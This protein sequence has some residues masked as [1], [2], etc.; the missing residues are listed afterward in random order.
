[1][2]FGEWAKIRDEKIV[3]VGYGV[4]LPFNPSGGRYEPGY[5]YLLHVGSRKP[6][7]NLARL[8]KAFAISGVRKNVRLVL[9]GTR[10]R[11]IAAQIEDLGLN[12]DVKFVGSPGDGAWRSLSGAKG[13]LFP[14]LYEGFG[15]PP[16]E[17][18]ACGLPVLTSNVCS[19][20]EVVGDAAILV[21]PFEVEVSQMGFGG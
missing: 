7:K 20:P 3:S 1:M 4:G 13:L 15:L 11:E 6:H 8:L 14:S 18:M 19:L 9:T 2:K 10:D 17:A 21:D 16:L 5:P 12:G